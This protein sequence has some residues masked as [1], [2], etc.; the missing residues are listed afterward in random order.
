[1]FNESQSGE[2]KV[3]PRQRP[4][5]W[6]IQWSDGGATRRSLIL[7]PKTSRERKSCPNLS[8]S[9]ASTAQL[10]VLLHVPR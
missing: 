7:T 3:G 4:L 8:S 5:P 2:A 6:N 10:I 9:R 1:M